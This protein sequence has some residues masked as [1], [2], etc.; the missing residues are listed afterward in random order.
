[1]AR[2]AVASLPFAA[3]ER[4]F[5]PVYWQPEF[6]FD[7]AD[8][9]GFGIEDVLFVVGLSA[10]ACSAYPFVT[11]RAVVDD[12]TTTRRAAL[13]RATAA[14]LAALASTLALMTADIPV[15]YACVVAMACVTF[16]MVVER[17][18]LVWPGAIGAFVT[19]CV[20][21]TL[22]IAFASL[23]PGVFAHTWRPS[24]LLPG[25]YVLGVPADELLYG[26]AAGLVG[27]VFPPWAFGLRFVTPRRAPPR[28]SRTRADELS[29]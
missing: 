26:G 20:Y 27:T 9:I 18:D 2:T 21:L 19:V 8:R 15:L 6:L 12:G 3:T 29:A 7:L 5:Y 25:A 17:R 1:M 28:E 13:V 4:L 10:I 14:I 24:V 22:C 16:V 11:R 23:V